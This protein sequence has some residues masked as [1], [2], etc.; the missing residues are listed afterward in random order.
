MRTLRLGMSGTDVME[1]QALLQKTGYNPG[2][3]DGVFGPQTQQSVIQFQQNF[4]LNPDGIIG[5]ATYKV[6]NRFLLGYDT[7]T[8]KSGDTFYNIAKKYY[9][10]P[11]LVVTANP[12]L[13]P[14]M[15]IPG[16][17]ITV[18]YGF[19]IVDTNISYTYDIMEKDIQGLQVRYPF[20]EVGI[21]GTS[22]LGR[23]LYYIKI[24]NGPNQVFY[25]GV[26]HSLEWITAPLLMKFIEQFSKA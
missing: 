5:P 20:L 7:Y 25:N 15:L 9:T 12:S 23:K 16:Q 6:L 21:A 19:D 26:H 24:G 18:P 22:V 3:V 13:N 8:I 4:V 11:S 2:S 17:A 1:I 14:T 10:N